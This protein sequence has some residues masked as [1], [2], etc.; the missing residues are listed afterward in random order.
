MSAF[1][2]VYHTVRTNRL[3]PIA[4]DSFVI[5]EVTCLITNSVS[6]ENPVGSIYLN[7]RTTYFSRR[8]L[9]HHNDLKVRMF[10]IVSIMRG[11]NL[12]GKIV[13]LKR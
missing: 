13:F 9:L 11:I 1:P 7:L 5:A 3:Q 6:V 4:F 10:V 8:A 12:Y 2:L